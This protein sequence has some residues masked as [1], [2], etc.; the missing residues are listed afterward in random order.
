MWLSL[1]LACA[2][3]RPPAAPAPAAAPDAP[4]VAASAPTDA[5]PT[6]TTD[7]PVCADPALGS[8]RERP[9]EWGRAGV[10]PRLFYG[11]L[12][13]PDGSEPR[14]QLRGS[15]GT[16]PMASTSPPSDLFM[17]LD[18]LDRWTVACASGDVELF[19]NIYRCGEV[20]VPPTVRVLPAAVDAEL[21]AARKAIQA[22][23][24]AAALA[25]ADAIVRAAPDFEWAWVMRAV[26]AK[27]THDV[28][29]ALAAMDDLLARWD[30]PRRRLNR[31]H[32]LI[33]G[34]R[35]DEARAALSAFSATNDDPSLTAEVTC[36]ESALTTD[37][38]TADRLARQSCDAGFAPC[39]EAR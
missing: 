8:A 31:V 34:G 14:S 27:D 9:L 36:T 13:C 4:P 20:C 1:L 29:A 5:C 10:G 3:H 17:P 19:V 26:V 7:P 18:V 38:A 30:S 23:D 16:A 39:C 37:P 25:H 33:G 11:R 12:V 21:A 35:V 2:A 6:A 32:L 28:D 15:V 24:T 22:G